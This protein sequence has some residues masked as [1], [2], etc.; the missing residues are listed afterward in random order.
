[1]TN[2]QIN[3]AL[4]KHK[5][6][7]CSCGANRGFKDFFISTEIYYLRTYDVAQGKPVYCLTCQ[8]CGQVTT[9]RYHHPH[10][11]SLEELNKIPPTKFNHLKLVE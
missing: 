3:D 5:D 8:K 10:E 6:T 11:V 9:Y 7:V 1:M 2:E 4:L